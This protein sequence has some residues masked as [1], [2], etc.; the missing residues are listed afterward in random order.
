MFGNLYEDQYR[1]YLQEK[2]KPWP[3]FKPENQPL[4][5]NDQTG[6]FIIISFPVT[7]SVIIFLVVITI[8]CVLYNIKPLAKERLILQNMYTL[9]ES[10]YF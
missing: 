1:R 2:G 10:A 9:H 3:I 7:F 5:E 8:S 6:L 4:Y